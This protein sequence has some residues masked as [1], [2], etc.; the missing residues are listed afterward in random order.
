MIKILNQRIMALLVIMLVLAGLLSGCFPVRVT[1]S[2]N[3]I[4]RT[5]SFVDFTKARISYG[6][7]A[8]VK[9]ASTY[10]VTVTAD[11]NIFEYIQVDK[12]GDT[13]SIGIKPGS[14]EQSHLQ[15]TILMP[16]L[17]GIELSD[18]GRTDISGFSS[19]NDLS[20][21]LSDGTDLSGSLTA[22]NVDI[23]LTDG[24][25]VDL[26]GSANS[27]EVTS[28]DGSRAN[29]ENFTVVNADLNIGDG[30]T[31]AINITGTLNA[32]LSAGSR[33]TY[34]GNPVLGTI[35]ISSGATLS[36]KD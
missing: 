26:D 2:G 22:G 24:S 36:K 17:R 35:K 1:G 3:I 27:I 13:I 18:G 23:N 33:V 8:E 25:R 10:G 30:G 6:F 9:A 15:A 19:S 5:F 20:I 16:A 29:L 7:T 28:H 31:L 21:K 14:Y 12:D 4:S 32:D 11:D 34:T